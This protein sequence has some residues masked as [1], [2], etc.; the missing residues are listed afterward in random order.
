M[1]RLII[2]VMVCMFG[3]AGCNRDKSQTV[4][5]SMLS[6]PSSPTQ[7]DSQAPPPVADSQ[8]QVAP[9]MPTAGPPVSYK[10][11]TGWSQEP[12][13]DMRYATLTAPDNVQIAITVF[14]GDVGGALANVNRWRRQMDLSGVTEAQLGTTTKTIQTSGGSALLVDLT[15]HSQRL[16][17]AMLPAGGQTWFFKMMGPAATIDKR[18]ADYMTILKSV[19]FNSAAE[20]G[21]V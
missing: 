15:N 12:G 13:R 16:M 18:A 9:A 10:L 21:S 5:T 20:N 14:S 7:A 1:K 3:I 8:A 6:A 4:D 19:R 11:P 2:C 17:A